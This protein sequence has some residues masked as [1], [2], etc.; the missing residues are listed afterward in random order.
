MPRLFLRFTFN[1]GFL[2]DS[3]F[4]PYV[5]FAKLFSTIVFVVVA[6]MAVICGVNIGF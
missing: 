1:R 2:K 5:I 4:L 3:T 6:A